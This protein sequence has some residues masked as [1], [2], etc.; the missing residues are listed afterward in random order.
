M[1]ALRHRSHPGC[2]T[3]WRMSLGRSGSPVPQDWS[4]GTSHRPSEEVGQGGKW[5]KGR[6]RR[7]GKGRGR[8]LGKGRGRRWIKEMPG[9]SMHTCTCGECEGEGGDNTCGECEGE[10][11]DNTCGECEGHIQSLPQ[12]AS[13]H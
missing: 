11:G 4:S 13:H 3:G 10:G 5:G 12:L 8:R 6:G 2:S 7:W 1:K 9:G